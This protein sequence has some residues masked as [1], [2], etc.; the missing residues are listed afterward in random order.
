MLGN[1]PAGITNLTQ[2]ITDTA[3]STIHQPSPD[4]VVNTLAARFRLT[5]CIA[6]TYLGDS[7]LVV[8][9]PQ[10][11]LADTNL[12]SQAEYEDRAAKVRQGAGGDNVQPHAYEL[13]CRVYLMMKRTGETQ[14]VVYR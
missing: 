12:A 9:N 2:L 5:D 14:S 4:L 10:R 11:A 13:A 6:S 8:L 3:T 1:D 7:I